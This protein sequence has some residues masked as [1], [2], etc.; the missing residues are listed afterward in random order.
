MSKK[1]KQ[2][3]WKLIGKYNRIA[4][5][6]KVND[7]IINCY[8]PYPENYK[9]DWSDDSSLDL[10]NVCFAYLLE[11]PVIC[12]DNIKATIKRLL[13]LNPKKIITINDYRNSDKLELDSSNI[14][15]AIELIYKLPLDKDKLI[16]IRYGDK[17]QKI[18]F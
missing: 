17:T 5:K 9:I 2:I 7:C 13:G 15:I 6:Y 4:N 16:E 1:E 14:I 3:I 11:I 10:I 8:N 12:D 18:I